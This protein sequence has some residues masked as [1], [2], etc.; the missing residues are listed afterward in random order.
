[1]NIIRSYGIILI[2]DN[3]ILMLNRKNSIYYIEFL[4]GKYNFE[5]IKSIELIFSRMTSNEKYNILNKSFDYLWTNLW[6]SKNKLKNINKYNK[7]F[8]KYQILKKN[9]LLLKRLCNIKIYDDTEW[10]FSKGRK[11][12]GEVNIDCA[13]RELKEETNI[14]INDY[15]IIKNILPIIE[16]YVSTNNVKYRICYYVGIYNSVLTD[17]DINNDEVNKVKWIDINNTK[18]YIRNYNKSKLDVINKVNSIIDSY[19]KEYYIINNI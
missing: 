2:K 12:K 7:G 15:D 19:N 1:M 17:I 3:K 18:N 4:M 9:D 5:N 13:I 8:K 10:E 6:G 16:E 14:D 11:N